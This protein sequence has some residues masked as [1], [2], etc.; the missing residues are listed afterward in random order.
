[1]KDLR[2]ALDR[3][4][5]EVAEQLSKG[6]VDPDLLNAEQSA[7]DALRYLAHVGRP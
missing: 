6:A 4:Q 1:M 3:I 7:R 5:Y 2:E